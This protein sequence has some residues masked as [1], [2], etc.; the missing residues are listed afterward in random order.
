MGGNDAF[1]DRPIPSPP[2]PPAAYQPG[3]TRSIYSSELMR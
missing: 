2:A 3:R 1:R